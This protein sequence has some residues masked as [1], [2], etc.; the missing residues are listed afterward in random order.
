MAP[1]DD[2]QPGRFCRWVVLAALVYTNHVS[3]TLAGH[4]GI[5]LLKNN[6]SSTWERRKLGTCLD[7]NPFLSI[8]HNAAAPLADHQNVTVT[9]HGVIAPSDL[10]WLAVV[11]PSN[12]DISACLES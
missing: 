3:A 12:S 8:S 9:V 5:P 2:L 1:C 10:D 11:T 7:P 4:A 6:N